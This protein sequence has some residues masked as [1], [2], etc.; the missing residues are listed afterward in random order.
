MHTHT[1][2]Q[3]MCIEWRAPLLTARLWLHCLWT[4]SFQ[5]VYYSN[6]LITSSSAGLSKHTGQRL[7]RPG[8]LILCALPSTP[9]VN[10]THPT[11]ALV[12]YELL[13]N[14]KSPN[15]DF[16]DFFHTLLPSSPAE[17]SAHAFNVA[18]FSLRLSLL[19]LFCIRI[20]INKLLI[21]RS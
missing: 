19:C 16:L 2:T 15:C 10:N 4:W 5:L 18:L 3:T 8:G 1:H 13:E 7:L 20:Q 17:S 14:R 21:S 11:P 9:P 6:P 12:T